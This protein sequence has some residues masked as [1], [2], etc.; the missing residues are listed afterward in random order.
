MISHSRQ[1]KTSNLKYNE[2]GREGTSQLYHST[3]LS[4]APEE[5]AKL[6]SPGAAS[7]SFRLRL[8]DH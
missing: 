5:G 4:R 1:S 3:V 7:L 6:E 8:Y 2:V